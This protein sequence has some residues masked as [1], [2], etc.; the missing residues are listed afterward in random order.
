M[1]VRDF[2]HWAYW[3]G[4]TSPW[5]AAPFPRRWF[6]MVWEWEN[7]QA[8]MHSFSLCSPLKMW[9]ALQIPTASTSLQWCIILW[10]WQLKKPFPLSWFCH[11]VFLTTTR[12][13]TTAVCTD[14]KPKYGRQTTSKKSYGIGSPFSSLPNWKDWQSWRENGPEEDSKASEETACG[15]LM[16]M[17]AP[18]TLYTAPLRLE[19]WTHFHFCV[20]QN[21]EFPLLRTDKNGM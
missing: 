21:Q 20:E 5:W 10:N 13:I 1:P 16:G 6:W 4:R 15:L 18:G 7:A 17:W 8:H 19:S 3:S 14:E 11:R 2:L 12:K 9:L